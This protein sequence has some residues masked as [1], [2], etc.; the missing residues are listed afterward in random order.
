MTKATN[1]LLS[2][3]GCHLCLPPAAVSVCPTRESWSWFQ[4]FF[5]RSFLY[6]LQ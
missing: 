1:H 4:I 3:F 6:G 5:S 2:R